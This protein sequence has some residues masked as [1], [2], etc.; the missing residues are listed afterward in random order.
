MKR[1]L[2]FG[3]VT[4]CFVILG[5]VVNATGPGAP[6]LVRVL[7]T[8]ARTVQAMK[9]GDFDV[10]KVGK[11]FVEV[12]CPD[13]NHQEFVKKGHRVE[14]LIPDLDAHVRQALQSSRTGE[15][16][17][18]YETMTAQMQQWLKDYP[19]IT[20][21]ESIGKSHE[22]RDLWALKISDNPDQD[23]PE[24]AVLI[25]GAHH[26]RE[27]PSFEV[28][29]A[30]IK[31]LL[32]GNGKDVRI[33]RLIKERE[34]WFV[35]MVNPDG[36][37]Y[38]QTNSRYWRK[39]RRKM[40][41]RFGV[42]PN[43]NYSWHWSESGSSS[44]ESSDTYHGPN[45]LSEPEN[46][47][48]AR[49]AK[50]ERFQASVSI[51]TYSQL[52]LYPWSWKSNEPCSDHPTL[53][54]LAVEMAEFN[55]YD[56]IVSAELYPAAGDSDDYL[57]GELKILAYTFELCSTFIPPPSEIPVF[58]RL[59]VPALIHLIDKAGPYAITT[60]S[61]NVAL[62]EHLDVPDS[63]E[64]VRHAQAVVDE[65][66]PET[67]TIVADRLNKAEE[68]LSRLVADELLAGS[69][70]TWENLQISDFD[71]VRENVKKRVL[72]AAAHGTQVRSD[73]SWLVSH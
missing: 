55:K 10:A 47:A 61:G 65:M 26:A 37:V 57:Y 43:R 16:Y 32:E 62:L 45:P 59:N 52:I 19:E 21:M 64:A 7:D 17:F 35:P 31:E 25:M 54:K 22:G 66:G 3:I 41:T 40:G 4:V 46:Q 27:W 44:S 51:H 38:S 6:S 13:G 14:V 39:N 9:E 72:F 58:N 49:F 71:K 28:P 1:G 24:P 67:G 33:S 15:Q 8:D 30:T 68:H 69:T 48:V 60:P 12:V 2:S 34:I 23:E 18:T 20:R 5:L 53:R 36:V 50:R 29:M 70:A 56:P 11:G 73:I 63:M 42:D